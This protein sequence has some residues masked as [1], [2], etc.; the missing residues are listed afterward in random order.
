[1]SMLLSSDAPHTS[2][3][4][5]KAISRC[6]PLVVPGLPPTGAAGVGSLKPSFGPSALTTVMC[7]LAAE[8]AGIAR[9]SAP[10]SASGTMRVAEIVM[11]LLLP[12]RLGL[13]SEE[14]HG[15]V[16]GADAFHVGRAIRVGP[17]DQHMIEPVQL[18]ER[19]AAGRLG[20][21][22]AARGHR[23]QRRHQL[24]RFLLRQLTELSSALVDVNLPPRQPDGCVLGAVRFLS[25]HQH[26]T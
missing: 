9:R 4:N 1:M 17:A 10:A 22:L 3:A 23:R 7:A 21:A 26:V 18:N 20:R 25:L 16:H 12:V 2:A 6:W 24:A 13:L 19:G 14:G 11:A 8:R 15:G 5:W